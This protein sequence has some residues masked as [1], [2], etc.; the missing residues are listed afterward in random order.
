MDDLH[1]PLTFHL[2]QTVVAIQIAPAMPTVWMVIVVLIQALA[3]A[4]VD[5][6]KLD[7]SR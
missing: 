1:R 4:S 5:Y 7:T 3:L 6:S 2:A